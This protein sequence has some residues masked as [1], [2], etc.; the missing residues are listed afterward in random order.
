MYKNNKLMVFKRDGKMIPK[1]EKHGCIL[2]YMYCVH[3]M[4][5]IQ[6]IPR[7]CTPKQ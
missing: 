4:F 1:Q 5:V 2:Y 6:N 3:V 7:V